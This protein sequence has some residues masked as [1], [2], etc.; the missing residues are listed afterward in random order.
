MSLHQLPAGLEILD[1]L[2]LLVGAFGYSAVREHVVTGT[3]A[4]VDLAWFAAADERLR[5]P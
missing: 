2:E 1:G 4:A 5:S 3:R